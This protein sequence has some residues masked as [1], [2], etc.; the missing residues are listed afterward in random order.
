MEESEMTTKIL[1]SAAAL[2]LLV[3]MGQPLQAQEQSQKTTG[4]PAQSNDSA[5]KPKADS[6][7]GV[8]SGGLAPKELKADP[9]QA[10][11]PASGST[12]IH[13]PAENNPTDCAA[14]VDPNKPAN[15]ACGA[16]NAAAK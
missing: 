7:S 4:A 6:A 16:S 10:P 3:G 11:A 15:P 9:P 12:D 5:N 1:V 2:L 8:M 13:K 14:A